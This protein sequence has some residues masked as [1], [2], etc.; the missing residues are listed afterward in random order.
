MRALRLAAAI[1]L[2][3]S[4]AVAQIPKLNLLQDNKPA[5]T[6]E[7]KD[8]DDAQQK[9]YKDSLKKIPDAKAPSDPWGAVRSTDAPSS[10]AKSAS[11]SKPKAKSR[12][13][14]SSGG[15]GN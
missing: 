1:M 6:Q 15:S 14:A 7:E 13:S 11:S 3:A 4:P 10:T 9:A 8:A 2:L 5:K 12:A